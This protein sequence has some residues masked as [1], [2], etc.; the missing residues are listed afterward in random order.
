MHI[1]NNMSKVISDIATM[2]NLPIPTDEAIQTALS[3]KDEIALTYSWRSR[4]KVEI[5][6][7]VSDINSAN[8]DYIKQSNPWADVIYTL[9]IDNQAVFMQ[10]HSPFEQGWIPIT[11]ATVNLVSNQHADEIAK[12]YAE[13][14]I[15]Q[16]LLTEL[17]LAEQSTP[18]V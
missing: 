10:T 5:W 13:S 8:A 9:L 16:E 4:I 6:D 1:T 7:G 18:S 12:H 14:Q 17:G 15:F 3:N 11:A 2:Q